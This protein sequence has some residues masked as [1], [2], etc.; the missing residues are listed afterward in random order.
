MADDP[1][2]DALRLLVRQAVQFIAEDERGL[3]YFAGATPLYDT[4]RDDA[5]RNLE[6]FEAAKEQ[7][8][9]LPLF[10]DRFGAAA[11]GRIA[12]QFVYQY[13]IG[14]DEAI[15]DLEQFV[16]TFA[17]LSEELEEPDWTF[18]HLANVRQFESEEPLL[19]FGDGLT[20]RHRDFDEL[21]A[22][23]GWGNRELS[24]LEDDW[25]GFGASNY[26]LYVEH[27][28]PKGSENL[29]L[30]S[31][32]EGYG[33]AARLLQALWIYKAG[34]VQI[35]KLFAER[36]SKFVRLGGTQTVG[37]IPPDVFGTPYQLDASEIPNVRHIFDELARLESTEAVPGNV[38]L[39]LRRFSAIY[40]RA[41]TQR[42]D[43]ILDAITALEALLGS[44]DEL[45]FKLSYRVANILAADNDERVD[46]FTSMK[47]FYRTRSRIVHGLALKEA[48]IQLIQD[49]APLRSVVR[50]LLRGV[51]N[52]IGEDGF[53]LTSNYVDKELD[54]IL[55][56][57]EQRGELRNAMG[58]EL[59]TG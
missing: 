14:L 40:S 59:E 3:G 39:A 58:L 4:R 46:L 47:S 23:L 52:L 42:E 24:Q 33:L 1:A 8:V 49:D 29:V 48:D 53:L 30:G 32:G 50:R 13:L 17:S 35:G 10:A 25:A 55:L 21:H 15:F 26:I 20:I 9:T 54:I 57:E 16:K 27:K 22:Q 34:D 18:V 51:L 28:V 45:T 38:F 31:G 2:R 7:V 12:L 5:I 37:E 19:D 41:L 44:K 36:A 43:R 6:S 56:H 11:G